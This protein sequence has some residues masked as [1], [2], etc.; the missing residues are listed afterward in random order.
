MIEDVEALIT[1]ATGY[2]PPETDGAFISYL[3]ETEGRRIEND[4]N[5]DDVPEELDGLRT[6]R[7]AAQYISLKKNDILGEDGTMT[8]RSIREGDVSVE[9]SGETEAERLDALH[10]ALMEDRGETACFRKLRW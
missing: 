6:R 8:A 1:G 7:T 3:W 10:A 4:I 5:Q 9:L 2:T